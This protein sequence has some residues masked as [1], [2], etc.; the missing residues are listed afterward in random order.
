MSIKSD[1]VPGTPPSAPPGP[2][3]TPAP[4]A[5][6]PTPTKR[7]WYHTTLSNAFVIGAVGFLAPGL[8]NAM[9]NL[10]AGGAQEPYLVNAANAL[11]F[12]I[13]GLLCLFGAPLANRIGLS[14]TLFL[15]AV[16]YPVYSAGLYANNRFGN[17]WLVLVGAVAC[18]FSA[19]LFWA[20]E[21][22]VALGYPEPGKRG[23][24]LN[25]WLW[26]RTGGPLVGGAIVLA[27]NHDA[28][29]KAKGKV[30]Y[31]TYLIFIAL[32]CVAAPLALA[33]SPPEKVQR[34]DGSKVVIRGEGSMRAEVRALWVACKRKDIV[35]LLPIFW[36]AYF[37]QYSG[38]FQSYYFGVRARALTGFIVNLSSLLSS[39]LVSA[40]L[41]YKGLRVKQRIVYGYWWVF[42]LHVVAW[43]YGWV[44][45]EKYTRNPPAYDWEDKGFVE[46]FFV[47][48]LWDFARQALQ[49][50][51]CESWLL[52]PSITPYP[53]I[54][55]DN[56]GF[57]VSLRL[58]TRVPQTT[59]SPAR[60]IT[61][62]N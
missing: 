29:A 53:Y 59:S 3:A 13:M 12:G 24:Y 41:D 37:N 44:I 9:S 26:F 22:A 46:G 32:Q 21:G 36:A 51:L 14:R 30:G 38:N 23:R 2:A 54:F 39:Q 57:L 11:V 56:P 47:L 50:W 34:A 62:L 31:E 55:T 17:T 52:I 10:G 4:A 7:T 18:G 25:I 28:G 49:N 43:T 48:L 16:G 19:G 42:L 1:T 33:L 20:S 8:W 40:L 6:S 15:G 5:T 60:R 45:Q 61:S 27:L 35:L 58:L